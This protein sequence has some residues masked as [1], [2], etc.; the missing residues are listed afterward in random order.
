MQEEQDQ[1]KLQHYFGGQPVYVLRTLE[2]PVVIPIE[3]RYQ[4]TPD[5]RYLLLTP[6]ERAQAYFDIPVRLFDTESE[7]LTLFSDES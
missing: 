7:I 5:L 6:E 3:E 4:N 2:G 1:L